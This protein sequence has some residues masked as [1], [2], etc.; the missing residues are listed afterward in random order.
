MTFNQLQDSIWE[1]LFDTQ[2]RVSFA[3]DPYKLAQELTRSITLLNTQL[4]DTAN[5][6]AEL[7]RCKDVKL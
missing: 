3:T 1:T 7:E 6:V 2:L 5:M 4:I